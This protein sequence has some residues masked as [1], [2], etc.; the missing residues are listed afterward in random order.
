MYLLCCRAARKL[1]KRTGFPNQGTCLRSLDQGRG[2]QRY[3]TD[4]RDKSGS[5]PV[6]LREHTLHN[7]VNVKVCKACNEGW[8]RGLEHCAEQTLAD[9]K[10]GKSINDLSAIDLEC[11]GRWAAK[12]AAALSFVTPQQRPVPFA[13]CASLEPLSASGPQCQVFYYQVPSPPTIE[14]A[15]LQIEYGAE[16]LIQPSAEIVG[17]RIALC[18]DNHCFI[19][20]FPVILGQ[21]K[22]NLEASPA[23]GI[24]P[25]RIEPGRIM[26]VKSQSVQ[27]ILHDLSESIDSVLDV[28]GLRS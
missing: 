10:K 18:V 17:T 15:Y 22:Y 2:L 28:D 24:W 13:A 9:L 27:Q 20:D 4:V 8:M 5:N 6:V 3:A 1:P 19:V 23:R 26:Q 21:T 12:T 11:L 16:V 25:R 7:L 14:G